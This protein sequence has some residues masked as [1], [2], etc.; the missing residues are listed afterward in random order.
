MKLMTIRSRYPY[1]ALKTG[2]TEADI[3]AAS[4]SA[5]TDTVLNWKI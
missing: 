1:G 5:L 2:I 4:E 3:V